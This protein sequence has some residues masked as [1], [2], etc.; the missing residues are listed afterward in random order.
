MNMPPLVEYLLAVPHPKGGTGKLCQMGY[1]HLVVNAWPPGITLRY[2]AFPKGN[3]YCC[4]DYYGMFSP[5]MVPEA[6]LINI[7]HSGLSIAEQ[8]AGTVDLREGTNYWVEVTHNNPIRNVVTNVSGLVQFFESLDM[9][10]MIQSEED[11]NL[12]HQ[13]VSEWRRGGPVT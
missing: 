12:V 11:Y 4:I 10:L 9:Y 2:T 5:S 7:T 3:I 13:I 1:T 6:F 8:T